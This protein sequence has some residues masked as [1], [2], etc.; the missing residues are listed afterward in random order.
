MRQLD[1]T[2][3]A[4]DGKAV[5]VHRWLPDAAPRALI[6][7]A[8]GMAEHAARY[9]RLAE[10]LTAAGWV[11]YAPDHR[12]HGKTASEGE[13]GWLADSDGVRRVAEDLHEIAL[14]A[15]AAYPGLP[16]FLLGHSFGSVASETYLG[17][18]ARADGLAGCALSG[19][20]EP[21]SPTLKPVATLIAGLGCLFKGQMAPAKLLDSMSFSAFNDEVEA[22]RTKCDWLSRDPAEVDTYVADP[23]C[24]F[25][26]SNGFYR[27]FLRGFEALYRDGGLLDAVPRDLPVIVMAGEKDPVGQARGFAAALT[28]RLRGLGLADVTLKVYPGA[29]HEIL[30]ETNRDEV[31]RDLVDWLEARR[32]AGG[33]ARS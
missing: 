5:H 17:L 10:A 33:A 21:P 18:H 13:L 29:R 23:L 3:A 26:V 20:P 19:P 24:G 1:F 6:L 8:H 7:V 22:P 11:V 4:S 27:D 32:A 2:H 14:A 9:A 16:L 15:K 30:N 25:V 31:T 28:G 12:G